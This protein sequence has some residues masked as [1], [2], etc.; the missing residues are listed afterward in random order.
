M[1]FRTRIIR[2]YNITVDD[3]YRAYVIIRDAVKGASWIRNWYQAKNPLEKWAMRYSAALMGIAGLP[4][5][6]LGV[7]AAVALTN[8]VV[9]PVTSPYYGYYMLTFAIVVVFVTVVYSAR[10]GR[11]L[12]RFLERPLRLEYPYDY[13]SRSFRPS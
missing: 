5:F 1:S 3:A 4:G 2:L 6:L 9:P 11:R 8:N 12:L 10:I 7:L 13:V